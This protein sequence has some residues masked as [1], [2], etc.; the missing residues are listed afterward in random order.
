MTDEWRTEADD[1]WSAE[2]RSGFMAWLRRRFRFLG[3]VSSAVSH[4]DTG[5]YAGAPRDPS[6]R[7]DD[8]KTY[9]TVRYTTEHVAYTTTAS[10]SASGECPTCGAPTADEHGIDYVAGTDRRRLGAVSSCPRC[11]ASSWLARSRMPAAGRARRAS[12]KTVL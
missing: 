9:S 3:G 10:G 6:L 2:R 4:A 7:V 1:A 11:A 8:E 12:R 5:P